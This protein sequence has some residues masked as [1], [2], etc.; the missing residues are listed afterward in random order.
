MW[1]RD[2]MVAVDNFNR[3]DIVDDLRMIKI[4]YDVARR[5]HHRRK[6]TG[7]SDGSCSGWTYRS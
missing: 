1:D 5:K 6:D 2:G 4:T 7:W 3:L